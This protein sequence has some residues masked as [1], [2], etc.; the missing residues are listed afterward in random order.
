MVSTALS[1]GIP[2]LIGLYFLAAGI[3]ELVNS[4]GYCLGP[5]NKFRLVVGVPENRRVD[6]EGAYTYSSDEHGRILLWL[7]APGYL[8]A[9]LVELTLAGLLICAALNNLV[10]PFF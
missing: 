8:P 9:A 6:G 4:H 2:G 3:V 5:T 1:I 7:D 10:H